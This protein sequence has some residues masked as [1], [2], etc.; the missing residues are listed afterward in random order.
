MTD[1]RDLA[2]RLFAAGVAAADP[3]AALARAFDRD[4][5]PQSRGR[6]IVIAV[7]KAAPAMLGEALRHITADDALAVTHHE[8]EAGVSVP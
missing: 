2:R 3:A 6:M 4:G 7:G 5:V 8:N 1:L